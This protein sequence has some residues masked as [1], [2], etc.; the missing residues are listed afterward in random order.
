MIYIGGGGCPVRLPSLSV[1]SGGGGVP[2]GSKS[3]VRVPLPVW[4]SRVL[5]FLGGGVLSSEL[6]EFLGGDTFWFQIWCQFRCHFRW[7]GGVPKR[8]FQNLFLNIFQQFFRRGG[9]T[10]FP[11]KFFPK[12]F[13]I[14]FRGVPKKNSE[15]IFF[16]IKLFFS[17]FWEG[18]IS[19]KKF[20]L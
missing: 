4:G 18:G 15:F 5:E 8:I 20:F 6:L 7:G 13:P 9:G 3:S 14:V 12:Y 1:W 19:E 10:I 17:F 2:S 11:P 16:A